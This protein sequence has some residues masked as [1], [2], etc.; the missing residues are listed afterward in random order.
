MRT[1][2]VIPTFNEAEN[3]GV[4]VRALPEDVAVLVVDD[5]EELTACKRLDGNVDRGERHQIR[6]PASVNR[7][8]GN[9]SAAMSPA[10]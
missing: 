7:S 1:A 6:P 10:T 3:I 9:R 8:F 5:H 4:L 2:V